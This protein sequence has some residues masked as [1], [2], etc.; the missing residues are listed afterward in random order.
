M[1]NG[2]PRSINFVEGG[3]FSDTRYEEK[4]QEK[5]ARHKALEE[6][7]KDY[8]YNVTTFSVIM[9]HLSH[10]ICRLSIDW[11]RAW[12]CKQSYVSIA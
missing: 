2:N 9:G 8:R 7:L 6:V 5:G 11:Y 3:Y 10:Y 12:T 4:L 1:P